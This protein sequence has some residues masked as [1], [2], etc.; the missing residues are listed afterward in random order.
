[1]NARADR[2]RAQDA[3]SSALHVAQ[4][5]RESGF[6][7]YFAGGCVRDE[8]LGLEPTDY[9]VATDARPDAVETLFRSTAHVGASFGV[10]LVRLTPKDLPAIRGK[11]TIEVATFRA[12]GDYSDRRRPDS[13]VFADEHADAQRRDFTINA[14]FLDPLGVDAPGS[15]AS[16][17][18]IDHIGGRRDLEQGI[19]RA[20]GDPSARLAEDH[21]RA[22]RG[23]RFAARFGFTIE[24]ATAAAIRDDAA[25]LEGVSRER[26]G[27]ELRRMLAHPTRADAVEYLHRLGLT[28]RIVG[29]PGVRRA[30]T[31]TPGLSSLPSEADAILALAAW[32]QDQDLD[33]A[34]LRPG[35]CLSNSE[36]DDLHA[37]LDTAARLRFDWATAETPAR[38][39]L[40]GRSVAE[41]ALA[42]VAAVDAGL[43]G[44]I[45]HEIHALAA[46]PGGL[47]PKPFL[48]GEDLIAAGFRPGPSF[49][50]A[51]QQ[52]YDL[53]LS[54]KIR[55]KEAAIEAASRWI[56]EE[57]PDL[58]G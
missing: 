27:S 9:D 47:S 55:T 56:A 18:L 42:L 13:V 23:V 25:N 30:G 20:V 21:L 17:R 43:A 26:I 24:S 14:L 29:A 16:G 32:V 12:D 19:V 1:M 36:T 37:L 4:R 31:R 58:E 3:R 50:R 54:N 45:Q 48:T 28:E 52:A 38:K 8:L 15:S 10:V 40:A 41:R 51:L 44:T 22:L 46:T 49:G 35:L 5:L 39:R 57:N 2:S 33:L 6:T 11:H 53:Q 34:G 7:A